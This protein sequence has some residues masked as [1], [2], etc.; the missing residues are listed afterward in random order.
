VTHP[1]N[2]SGPSG[3][4]FSVLLPTHN[5]ADVIGLAIRSVLAQTEQDFELLVVGDGCTDETADVVARFA[6][7]RIRWFDLPKAPHFGYANRNIC[8]REARG[9]LVA[10]VA[11]DDL[12]VADHLA[13]LAAAFASP[14]IDWAYS[15]PMWVFDDGIVVPFAVDLTRPKEL[16]VFLSDHN[17]IPASCVMYRRTC[18]DRYGYWPEDMPKGGDWAYWKTI[19][20][21]SHGA[22]LAYVAQPTA[23]HFRANWRPPTYGPAPVQLWRAAADRDGWPIGLTIPVAT[24]STPQGAF[25]E[26][27]EADPTG[28]A[29]A[30][31]KGVDEAMNWLA[32]DQGIEISRLGRGQRATEAAAQER[33]LRLPSEP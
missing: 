33:I 16:D 25:W 7:E 24:G 14:T 11:H 13:Q 23:L 31:R 1:E 20:G 30:I 29:S 21:P 6:D 3:Q 32:W 18:H 10:I 8:L 27:M 26:A 17:T 19:V 12:V 15:R 4:K 2:R 28:F 22:N 5:R 9:E